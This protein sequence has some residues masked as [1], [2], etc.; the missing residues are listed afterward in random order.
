MPAKDIFKKLAT[1]QIAGVMFHTN[2]VEYFSYLN[3]PKFKWIQH[4]QAIEEYELLLS[5][6]CY[7][8]SEYGTTLDVSIDANTT[9]SIIPADWYNVDTILD[10]DKKREYIREGFAK[11][12]DWEKKTKALYTQLCND[13]RT[14]ETDGVHA[15]YI[16]RLV[17][18]VNE[19][20]KNVRVDIAKL[21]SYDY[22]LL[23]IDQ[24]QTY[25]KAH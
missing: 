11:W 25:K 16:S 13:M 24:M 3:L 21:T 8:T 20:I 6:L 14:L 17:A 9:P 19:E 18:D 5:T 23:T 22:D 12:L 7:Y 2:M 15:R 10:G 1:H 4:N